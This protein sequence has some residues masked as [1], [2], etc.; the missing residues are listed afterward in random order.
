M[1]N[2]YCPKRNPLGELFYVALIVIL[3]ITAIVADL[4]SRQRH[5]SHHAVPRITQDKEMKSR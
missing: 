3:A 5:D 2:A 1:G 4:R